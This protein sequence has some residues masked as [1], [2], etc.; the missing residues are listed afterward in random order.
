MINLRDFEKR[1]IQAF[2][3]GIRF[4]YGVKSYAYADT[5]GENGF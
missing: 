4:C 2:L 1:N 5:F 3:G